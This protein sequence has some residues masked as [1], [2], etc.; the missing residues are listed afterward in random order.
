MTH[1]IHP[2]SFLHSNTYFCLARRQWRQIGWA[3]LN[4]L[5]LISCTIREWG[6]CAW[7]WIW[8]GFARFGFCSFSVPFLRGNVGDRGVKPQSWVTKLSGVPQLTESLWAGPSSAKT[9][10]FSLRR[11]IW[12]RHSHTS[13]SLDLG[14][15]LNVLGLCDFLLQL[16]LKTK[17]WGVRGLEDSHTHRSP[18]PLEWPAQSHR[19]GLRTLLLYWLSAKDGMCF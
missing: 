18:S 7:A 11:G 8:A 3:I 16:L 6:S 14:S 13:C 12:R 10:N 15:V 1:K 2:H 19:A 4:T 5:I 17:V 9:P